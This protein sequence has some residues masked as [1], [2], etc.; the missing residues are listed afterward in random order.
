MRKTLPLLSALVLG[1]AVLASPVNAD[2][3]HAKNE[4]QIHALCGTQTAHVQPVVATL[5]C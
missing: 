3:I 5:C 1:A 2:P 4:S